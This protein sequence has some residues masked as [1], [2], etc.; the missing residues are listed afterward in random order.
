VQT[1]PNT[2]VNVP[3]N[4]ANPANPDAVGGKSS[5]PSNGNTRPFV[6]ENN[7]PNNWHDAPPN[8]YN[9]GQVVQPADRNNWP[10]QQPQQQQQGQQ[11]NP[12]NWN[13]TPRRD[14]SND[15]Q[16]T[17]PQ[18]QPVYTPQQPP[19]N[20]N[21]NRYESRPAEQPRNV[22]PQQRDNFQQRYEQPQR[23]APQQSAPQQYQPR[24][25]PNNG[26][27]FNRMEPRSGGS[28]SAPQQ[29]SFSSPGPSMGGGGRGGR[30]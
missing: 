18:Q 6:Q 30:H 15:Q 4:N 11:A 1:R 23:M 27:G 16:R 29:R 12:G 13:S 24:T 3:S 8:R 14:G 20:N 10:Q 5:Q 26:G 25:Q 21:W 7:A 2:G 22:A 17:A 19:Q 9:N 28:F